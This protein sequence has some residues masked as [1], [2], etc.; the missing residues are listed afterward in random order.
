MAPV[1]HIIRS[2]LGPI[3]SRHFGPEL[4]DLIRPKYSSLRHEKQVK[5]YLVK[6]KLG[7]RVISGY[8]IDFIREGTSRSNALLYT[9]LVRKLAYQSTS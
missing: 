9:T 1:A 6:F 2:L 4:K 8:F 3:L 7:M 5:F